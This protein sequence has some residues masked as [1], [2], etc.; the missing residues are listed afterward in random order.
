MDL[1]GSYKW[2][3]NIQ[4]YGALDNVFDTPPPNIASTTGGSGSSNLY[5][6]GI[7]RKFRLGIRFTY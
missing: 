3:E 7:G 1:R 2:N 6:D 5:Y 4:F